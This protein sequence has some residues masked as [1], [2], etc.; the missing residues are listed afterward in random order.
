MN[1]FIKNIEEKGREN[2]QGIFASAVE[3][4]ASFSKKF[5]WV[6]IYLLKGDHLELGPYIGTATSHARIPIGTGIC[7]RAVKE[8]QD[9]NIPNVGA[10]Q[11]YLACSLETQSELVVLIRNTLGEIIGQ[12]DIDSHTKNAFGPSEEEKV[13]E[14]AKILGQYGTGKSQLDI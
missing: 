14:V 9:L 1:D 12:I 7:G 4:L 6:G 11:N 5:N 10:E 8:E 3:Y 2:N 13:K